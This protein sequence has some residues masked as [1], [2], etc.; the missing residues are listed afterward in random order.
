MN[1]LISPKYQMKLVK[2]VHDAI[3]EEYKT[4]REVSLYIDKWHE[5]DEDWNNHWENFP[6][7]KKESG[8]IDLLRTLHSMNGSD[9]LKVAIDMGVDTPDFIPSIPTFKNELKSD[10][11]TAYD[12]FT[13]AFKQIESDPSLAVGLANSALESIVKEILKDE[14][15]KSKTKGT[16]TLYKLTTIII[17][18]FN[19]LDSN[20]P[21]EIK[22]IGS[23]LLSISQSI[24][25]LR[26]E[27]TDFHG[28]TEEDCLITDSIYT[29]F[30][31][32]A[33]TTVGLFLQSYF[34]TKLPKPPKEVEEE[35]DD[36]PF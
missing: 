33:V 2:S 8:D 24:E 25:K 12:T 31:V 3:W 30:V 4:Y 22:T 9:L 1:E 19:F 23:S 15:I 29:Y 21:V 5:V 14:R 6:I 32:N 18:E 28:K 13:K 10:F 26:S 16:E 27:K 20:H 35:H 36:L 17:K 7:I 34:K 11:K